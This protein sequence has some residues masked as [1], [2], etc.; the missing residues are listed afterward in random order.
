VSFDHGSWV[1]GIQ[2]AINTDEIARDTTNGC[3]LY[4]NMWGTGNGNGNRDG[5]AGHNGTE[6]TLTGENGTVVGPKGG[7]DR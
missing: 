5:H 7:Y 1:P 2:N 4:L 3:Y 6:G